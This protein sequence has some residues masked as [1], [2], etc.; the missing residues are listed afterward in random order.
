QGVAAYYLRQ[1][2][3]LEASIGALSQLGHEGEAFLR[4]LNVLAATD[5]Y[6]DIAHGIS[7][8]DVVNAVDLEDL[9]PQAIWSVPLEESLL[10]RRFAGRASDH[11]TEAVM[12]QR[13]LEADLTTTVPTVAGSVVLVNQGQSIL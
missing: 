8:L 12:R 10:H 5:D 2:Q 11:T 6:P 7:T 9:V 1:T 4:Q 13:L 3:T